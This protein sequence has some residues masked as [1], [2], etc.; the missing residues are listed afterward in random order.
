MLG[1][2]PINVRTRAY[3]DIKSGLSY[4][5]QLKY[6]KLTS[7]TATRLDKMSARG[8]PISGTL[9]KIP[10]DPIIVSRRAVWTETS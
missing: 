7:N 1:T 3:I 8:A 6:K 4:K 2:K 5:D 9:F 10:A